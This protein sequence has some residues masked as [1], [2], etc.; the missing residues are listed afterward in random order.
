MVLVDFERHYVAA[1]PVEA[2]DEGVSARLPCGAGRG[3]Q[4]AGQHGR[5]PLD[6]QFER[7]AVAVAPRAR[8]GQAI[9][10]DAGRRQVLVAQGYGK[11]LTGVGVSRAAQSESVAGGRRYKCSP[12][13]SCRSDRNSCR[14]DRNS[15]RSDRIFYRS[16][17]FSCRSTCVFCRLDG[18]FYRRRGPL[19]GGDDVAQLVGPLRAA[20]EV[21]AAAG[22]DEAQ[23]VVA[24]VAGGQIGERDV[25]FDVQVEVFVLFGQP[26]EG[27]EG[28]SLS[29]RQ[30]AA[31]NGFAA[32][33]VER[34]EQDGLAQ[35]GVGIVADEAGREGTAFVR[36]LEDVESVGGPAAEK[37]EQVVTE[38]TAVLA[39]EALEMSF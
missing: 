25:G 12:R 27:V 31:A 9:E 5:E 23:G 30:V 28:R 39:S 29:E 17:C 10:A 22:E 37:A 2:E 18:K 11:G 3:P 16:T 14:S 6:E 21:E 13:F 19:D 33:G 32:D 20:I 24:L 7:F 34:K 26:V 15:C 8:V 4:V 36:E 38:V 1:R 35:P